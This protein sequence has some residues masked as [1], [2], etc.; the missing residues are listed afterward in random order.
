MNW[1]QFLASQGARAECADFGDPAGELAAARIGTVLVPLYDLGVIGVSGEDALSFLHNLL[2]SDI[3]GLQTNHGRR[4]GLCTPKG[5]LIATLLVWRT[6]SGCWLVLPRD[7]LPAVLKKLAMYVLRS[8]VKLEDKTAQVVLLG[9]SGPACK[10]ALSAVSAIG[11][12]AETMT[13]LQFEQGSAL[14]LSPERCL[15]LLEANM[16]ESAWRAL[17]LHAR[18]AGLAT[19]HWLEI[20]AGVPQVTL[21]TQ[22]AFVPQMINYEIVGG[23]S[24]NKGC[25]PGQ[26]VVARSQYLGKVKRRMYRAHIAAPVQIGSELFSPEA[27]DQACGSVLQVAP[28]PLG[29]TEILAVIQSSSFEA[30]NVHL[31]T[32]GGAALRFLP[33][34]Y[35]PNA[36]AVAGGST[37]TTSS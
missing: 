35:D 19:W 36:E 1:N 17:S 15:L 33:L 3:K 9:I 12:V 27:G 4:A 11:G 37:K 26:E 6:E 20:T 8:K 22:E 18:P 23:V 28:S 25:Y 5:R 14:F 7:L 21:A 32:P 16:A 24:F 31:G 29:G 34:P 2:T 10:Q 30:G 13:S